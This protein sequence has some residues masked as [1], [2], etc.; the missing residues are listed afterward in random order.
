MLPYSGRGAPSRLRN[1]NC[2]AGIRVDSYRRELG[3]ED[4]AAA[5]AA[6]LD[7]QIEGPGADVG[8]YNG[9]DELFVW[10]E[11]PREFQGKGAGR[12]RKAMPLLHGLERTS[13]QLRHEQL[14]RGCD[15]FAEVDGVDDAGR[16]AFSPPGPP[17]HRQRSLL[18]SPARWQGRK[19]TLPGPIRER[20]WRDRP[21]LA[22]SLGVF[23]QELRDLV[24]RQFRHPE[25]PVSAL[26]TNC[27]RCWASAAT[28]RSR[29]TTDGGVPAAT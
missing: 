1:W 9:H 21:D 20:C 24:G 26:R 6:A 7:D 5:L 14:E 13:E 10:P 19:W 2:R 18:R 11:R 15:V 22:P 16:I 8:D 17:M 27:G 3:A 29:D 23:S 4:V 12:G 25:A 28:S